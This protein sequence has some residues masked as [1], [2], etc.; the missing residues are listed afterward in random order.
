MISIATVVTSQPQASGNR[1]QNDIHISVV[2]DIA[3]SKETPRCGCGRAGRQ[4]TR[5]SGL[6]CIHP[7]IPNISEYA[8]AFISK[9]HRIEQAIIVVVNELYRSRP[10][11]ADRPGSC[12][13]SFLAIADNEETRPVCT[14]KEK[15]REAILIQVAS[16]SATP[17]SFDVEANIF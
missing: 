4:I 1:E 17:V 2:I 15:I 11:R 13:E 5:Y 7:A 8:Q 3:C 6:A 10:L 14:T 12:F 9:H 16:R